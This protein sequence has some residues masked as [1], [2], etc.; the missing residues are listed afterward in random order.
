[1]LIYSHFVYHSW[2]YK[3]GGINVFLPITG[4]FFSLLFPTADAVI[5]SF[6]IRNKGIAMGIFFS[7]AGIGSIIGPWFIGYVSESVG[8]EW[9]FSTVLIFCI[10][11]IF[12]LF[13]MMRRKCE[14]SNI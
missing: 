8:I 9:D 13:A 6:G 11:M 10:L 5:A 3:F 12:A 7:C 1:M 14:N 4:L 2:S